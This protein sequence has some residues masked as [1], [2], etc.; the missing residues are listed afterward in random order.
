MC[1]LSPDSI[2]KSKDALTVKDKEEIKRRA[3]KVSGRF[4]S[5][6]KDLSVSHD[7]YLYE[8]Y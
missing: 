6:L 2:K 5:S 8:D 3:V 1:T 4:R 7:K